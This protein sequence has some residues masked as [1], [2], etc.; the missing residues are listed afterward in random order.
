MAARD[1]YFSSSSPLLFS[2]VSRCFMLIVRG[3][4]RRFFARQDLQRT[5][6]MTDVS[7]LRNVLRCTSTFVPDVGYV[8]VGMG[9]LI[10]GVFAP[11]R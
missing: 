9:M 5:L 8:Q 2:Y 3:V 4:P 11:S 1:P 10:V 6:G 7:P